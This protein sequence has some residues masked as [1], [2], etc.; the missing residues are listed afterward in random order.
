M[1]CYK[2]GFAVIDIQH[3]P[4]KP[5]GSVGLIVVLLIGSEIYHIPCL[6]AIVGKGGKDEQRG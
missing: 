4:F 1:A 2:E 5:F 6:K 3:P